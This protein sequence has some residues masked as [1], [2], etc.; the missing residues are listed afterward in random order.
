MKR[1][2]RLPI[3]AVLAMAACALPALRAGDYDKN[4]KSVIETSEEDPWAKAIR[5]ISNPTLF[6]LAIPRTQL[7]SIFIYNN[8]P[9][10]FDIVGGQVPLGGDY[11]VYALQFEYAL[12]DRLSLNATKD[13]YIV[14]DPVST[15]SDT[16]GFA[17]VALGPKYAWLLK[18]E[19]GLA[20]NVQLIYE[21]PMGNREA[22]QGEGDGVFIPS[23]STLKMAGRFQFSNQFGFKL[24]IDGDTESTMFYT[25]AHVS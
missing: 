5:P 18:P 7:H 6:D 23:V 19:K 16:E 14:F 17:N 1:I 22:W 3:C 20:S 8:M 13:G 21:I 9:D 2:T 4:P 25:S 12:T 10:M 15:L 11:Q 24:P